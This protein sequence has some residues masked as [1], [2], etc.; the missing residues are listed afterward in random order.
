[1]NGPT[2]PRSGERRAGDGDGVLKSAF[3]AVTEEE[4]VSTV[5]VAS[6]RAR[7][8]ELRLRVPGSSNPVLLTT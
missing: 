8:R 2:A 3:D 4:D 7:P 6:S 5:R 1:L